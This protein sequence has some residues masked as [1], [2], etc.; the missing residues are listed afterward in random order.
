M[1]M[2]HS[3]L[4][5]PSLPPWEG[6][7]P[8]LV[9][10]PIVLLLVAPLFV[11]L[12]LLP[13]IGG[14]FKWAALLLLVLGT[15]GAYIAVEAGQAAKE[16]V[17]QTPPI[18]EVLNR[19]QELGESVRT[20]FTIIT[21]VYGVVLIVPAVLAKTRLWKKELP[22]AVPLIGQLVVL[23]ALLL[24]GMVVANT[25]DLG[26]R[27]VHEFGVQAWMGPAK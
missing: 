15:I 3:P 13:R 8:V 16:L 7:H 22:R 6:L 5:P 23:A 17:V 14:A 25:G 27:L 18:G 2:F 10:F 12:G 19:H 1:A 26:G 4:L 24:C 9:H 11:L 20:L 21:A